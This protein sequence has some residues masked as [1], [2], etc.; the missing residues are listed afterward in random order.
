MPDNFRHP[1]R[2]GEKGRKEGVDTGAKKEGEGVMEVREGGRDARV[3]MWYGV[4]KRVWEE[5]F[6]RRSKGA[7][8]EERKARK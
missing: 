3:E 2:R 6:G 4:V 8:W 5:G 1:A 7:F